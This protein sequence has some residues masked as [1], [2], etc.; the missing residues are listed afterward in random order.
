MKKRVAGG[1]LALLLCVGALSGCDFGREKKLQ[2]SY[3]ADAAASIE[4]IGTENSVLTEAITAF[5]DEVSEE[6][7][8]GVME[9]LDALEEAYLAL[10]DLTAPEAYAG[11]QEDFR[12]GAELAR[13][14]IDIYRQQFAGVTEE[15][16]DDTFAE[17]VQQGDD[18]IR[19]AQDRI[20]DGSN[21]L[22]AEGSDSG[23]AG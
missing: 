6:T 19:R 2:E 11:V 13:Q 16:V 5:F 15:T 10:R 22:A 20:L 4:A 12:A 8:A 1:L 7:R 3:R 17:Q 23:A 18:L 9:A 14:A 21:T